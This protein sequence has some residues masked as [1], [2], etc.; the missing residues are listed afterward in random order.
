MPRKLNK[1]E[2]SILGAVLGCPLRTGS[3]TPRNGSSA[4]EVFAYWRSARSDETDGPTTARTG[5]FRSGASSRIDGRATPPPRPRRSSSRVTNTG[6][7][8]MPSSRTATFRSPSRTSTT[9][10]SRR[11][12]RISR[13]RSASATTWTSSPKPRSSGYCSRAARRS[14]SRSFVTARARPFVGVR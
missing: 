6:P 4:F 2:S 3:P 13:R 1:P 5:R 7:T 8:K 9:G 10:E 14:A 12:S 11:R